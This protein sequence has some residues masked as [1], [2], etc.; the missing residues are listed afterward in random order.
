MAP[1]AYPGRTFFVRLGAD[2]GPD[3]AR[4]VVVFSPPSWLTD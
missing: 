3:L 2:L 4:R 1:V